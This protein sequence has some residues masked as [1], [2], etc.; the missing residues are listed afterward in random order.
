MKA[1]ILAFALSA[2]GPVEIEEVDYFTRLMCKEG[3]N[4]TQTC[5]FYW[6]RETGKIW[7]VCNVRTL[8]RICKVH[9]P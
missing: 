2:T 1:A 4:V 9:A 3:P 8:A 7:E 6:E 5:T